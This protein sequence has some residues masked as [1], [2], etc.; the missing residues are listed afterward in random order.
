[1]SNN[2]L[3]KAQQ[4][5]GVVPGVIDLLTLGV[6]GIIELA[7]V[8]KY[9]KCEIFIENNH[10][11]EISVALDISDNN[12]LK[13]WY[14]IEPY[15]TYKIYKT[16]R[17]TYKVGIY[18][19]CTECDKTWGSENE[20]YIPSDGKAFNIDYQSFYYHNYDDKCVKFS[21]SS[22]IRKKK[23]YTFQID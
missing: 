21:Y 5:M 22:D 18:A 15:T 10:C 13:G 17:R 8:I 2:D 4:I 12:I 7:N 11:H 16:E 23:E 9:D 3:E 20:H 14:N 6:C 1:M 19:E